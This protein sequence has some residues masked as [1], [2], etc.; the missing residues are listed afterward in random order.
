MAA[1]EH[2]FGDREPSSRHHFYDK[3]ARLPKHEHLE[4]YHM[5][6]LFDFDDPMTDSD[7]DDLDE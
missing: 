2:T 7:Y 4:E 3:Q 5:H 1:K 6:D